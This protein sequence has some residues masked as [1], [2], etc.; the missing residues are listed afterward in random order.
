MSQ[1]GKTITLAILTVFVY[2]FSIFLQKGAFIFPFP[3][4]E[5]IF[6]IATIVIALNEFKNSKL[7]STLFISS[8][9]LNLFSSEFYWAIFLNTEQMTWFSKSII[10]DVL[11]IS[12][13]LFLIFSIFK[14]FKLLDKKKLIYSIF[15]IFG[16]ILS[17]I[18][19]VPFIEIGAL[20]IVTIFTYRSLQHFSILNLWF[21]L[22]VLESTK[23]WSLMG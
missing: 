8:A 4:N 14:S 1:A 22:F 11:K 2:A 10:T 3:L 18:F 12:Y 9:I 19:S 17:L 21:L 16:I 13:Y 6:L 15:P 20:L 5:L 23:L 7:I